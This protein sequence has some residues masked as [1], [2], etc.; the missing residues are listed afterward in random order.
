MKDKFKNIIFDLGGVLVGLDPKRC[1]DAFRKIGCGILAS[2]VEEHRTEDLFLDTELGRISQK[3]FCS[4]VR[5]LSNTDTCDED[6]V[7]AW[8]Q[9]LT[10]IPVAKLRLLQRLRASGY[11]LFLLSNTNVMHWSLC[12]D[13]LFTVDGHCA[14]DYFDGIFL[15]YEMHLAKPDTEIFRECLRQA[16]INGSDTLFVD[17]RKEN[18]MAAEEAG[19]STLHE[20]TGSK[21]CGKLDT[22]FCATI[23]FFDG[24]HR[25]HQFVIGRLVDMAG[26]LG[27]RSMVIT[28][29]RHPRQ[30]VQPDYVPQ[31][32]TPAD[33]KLQLLRQTGADHIEVL[34]F[35]KEMA[36]MSAREFM[37]HILY[38]RLGVRRLLIG[39]DNRF[40][41]NRA[42]GFDDYVRYGREIGIEVVHN[43]PVDIDGL[44]VSSSLVRRL[45]G[46]G[47]VAEA[48]RC[49]GHAFRIDGI[50]EHGFGEGRHMGFP[51]AN[52]APRCKEQILPKAGVYAVYVR[53]DGEGKWMDAMMNVGCN[54]TFGRSR[55]TLEAHII[56]FSGD[57]YGKSISVDFVQRLRDERKFSSA[58]ELAAQLEADLKQTESVLSAC[59]INNKQPKTE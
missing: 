47:N 37:Q 54:P 58:D 15:S 55:L 29:D 35:D 51:T 28:F 25:G 2:Y 38:E 39:Y 24:V 53:I 12:R 46:E 59:Q 50:V 45:L 19:I 34:P 7:W 36:S 27:M 33:S 6:I 9:L 21:W 3:E 57:I 48:S 42:E 31:L 13:R 26:K 56:N 32:I 30:V 8:N 20:T 22:P 49:L 10:D 5:R 40:G 23:G 11:R 14:T 17:D 1:I 43:E 52:I 44:R 41:H 16:G 4:E 18:C